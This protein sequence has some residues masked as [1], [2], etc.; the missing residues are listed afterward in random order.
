VLDGTLGHPSLPCVGSSVGSERYE[1]RR[2]RRR[3][4]GSGEVAIAGGAAT[5]RQYLSAGQIDELR[6]HLVPVVIGAGERL[7]DGVGRDLELE[8]LEVSGNHLVAHLTYRV[9]RPGETAS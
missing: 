4:A 6:L 7:L 9:V 8:P 5:A 2:S 3:S 1:S